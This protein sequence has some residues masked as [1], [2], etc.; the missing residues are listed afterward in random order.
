MPLPNLSV[1]HKSKCEKSCNLPFVGFPQ[2]PFGASTLGGGLNQTQPTQAAPFSFGGLGQTQA[3]PVHNLAQSG[4]VAAVDADPYGTSNFFSSTTTEAPFA[5][6]PKPPLT[7]RLRGTPRSS[8]RY[9]KLKGFGSPVTS[10][11]NLDRRESS[12]ESSTGLSGSPLSGLFPSEGFSPQAFR[13]RPSV[14]KLVISDRPASATDSRAASTSNSAR[15][16]EPQFDPD[17]E[18]RALN[19]DVRP[20]DRSVT[21]GNTPQT[22]QKVTKPVF[23][24]EGYM[25]LVGE[26]SLESLDD[27]DLANVSELTI[28]QKECG[29]V[30]FEQS[31]DVKKVAE[32]VGGL[33]KIAGGV[34]KITN[35]L[36]SVYTEEYRKFYP[37]VGEGLNVPAIVRLHGCWAHNKSNREPYKDPESSHY[38]QHLVKLKNN[39][40]AEFIDFLPSSG[41]WVF[42]VEHFSQWGL[43]DDDDLVHDL[44][45][46]PSSPSLARRP[47]TFDRRPNV[48]VRELSHSTSQ[49]SEGQIIDQNM[50]ADEQAPPRAPASDEESD[51]EEFPLEVD[52]SE[53][54]SPDQSS[55]AP[56]SSLSP[57]IRVE[58]VGPRIPA[59]RLA[60]DSARYGQEPGSLAQMQTLLFSESKLPTPSTSKRP[61]PLHLS[62]FRVSWSI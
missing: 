18:Y 39:R 49:S 13:A 12:I 19:Q 11:P 28:V 54:D 38:K 1:S 22:P 34:V 51:F 9:P 56:S 41:T 17:L 57:P 36:V 29:Q 8:V 50:E 35:R 59:R 5:E 25:I 32:K 52:H 40:S 16:S 21:V 33:D 60:W 4:A 10:P 26:N 53:E 37:P 44:D 15:Q 30:K 27:A 31:I 48:E 47:M 62:S 45:N 6:K 61:L 43:D 23:N 2:Q 24:A 42:R 20:R 14:K 46:L 7:L 3:A 58:R 55:H